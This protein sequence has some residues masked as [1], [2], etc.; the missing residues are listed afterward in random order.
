M[1]NNIAVSTGCQP[2]NDEVWGIQW[3]LTDPGS[4]AERQCPNDAGNT[5][6]ICS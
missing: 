4:I 5:M 6:Y 2:E 1:F 3:Q